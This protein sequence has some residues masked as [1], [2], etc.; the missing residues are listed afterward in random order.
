MNTKEKEQLQL[1]CDRI[2]ACSDASEAV[3]LRNIFCEAFVEVKEPTAIEVFHSFKIYDLL[4]QFRIDS[5]LLYNIN[6]HFSE[7]LGNA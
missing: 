7:M 6:H 5:D 2:N 3:E 1:V 4:L